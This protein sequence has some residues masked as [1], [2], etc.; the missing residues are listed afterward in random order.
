[1]YLRG[2]EGLSFI[3]DERPERGAT[4]PARP[5]PSARGGPARRRRPRRRRPAAAAR[6]E[7]LR[8]RGRVAARS[9][10]AAIAARVGIRPMRTAYSSRRERG[11][12]GLARPGGD[13][14]RSRLRLGVARRGR[15]GRRRVPGRRVARV[16]AGRA[17]GGVAAVAADPPVRAARAAA[18]SPSSPPPSSSP[19]SPPPPPSSSPP[20]SAVS[21]RPR[22][23]A[24]TSTQ[25]RGGRACAARAFVV[26]R[27]PRRERLRR[28]R[29]APRSRPTRGSSTALP[30]A[31]GASGPRALPRARG[32]G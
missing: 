5:A 10:A 19:S 4:C 7:D 12:V 29:R 9:I 14:G 22:R 8:D 3:P 23:A 25:R 30:P 24:A 21:G 15:R 1:M 28:R 32:V 11:G 6:R 17:P 27:A 20:S 13:P 18:S 26:G 2:E 31:T 16:L